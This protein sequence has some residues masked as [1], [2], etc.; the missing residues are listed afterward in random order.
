M[1]KDKNSY[2]P[3]V[4]TNKEE[5]LTII[6]SNFG[7]LS[8][9]TII[10]D[11]KD[12]EKISPQDKTIKLYREYLTEIFNEEILKSWE[13]KLILIPTLDVGWGH[14]IE[15]YGIAIDLARTLKCKVLFYYPTEYATLP[16]VELLFY[17]LKFD[18]LNAMHHGNPVE[19]VLLNL[20]NEI[21][22]AEKIKIAVLKTLMLPIFK[23]TQE[24]GKSKNGDKS[25][26]E[27]LIL[28]F[29]YTNR[30]LVSIIARVLNNLDI[31]ITENFFRVNLQ[32]MISTLAPAA[33]FTTHPYNVRAIRNLPVPCIAHIPDPGYG[34]VRSE[35]LLDD[36]NGLQQFSGYANSNIAYSVPTH[37]IQD[38]LTGIYGIKGQINITGTTNNHITPEELKKKWSDKE[39]T[40]LLSSNGNGSNIDMLTELVKDFINQSKLKNNPY[41]II[42]FTGEH[43]DSICRSIIDLLKTIPEDL[44][45]KVL[46]IRTADKWHT[47]VKK[48]ELIKESHVEI[49]SMGEQFINI[50]MGCIPIATKT[51][52]INECRNTLWAVNTKS[53]LAFAYK[54]HYDFW[55]KLFKFN[56]NTIG[57]ANKYNNLIDYLDYIFFSDN[58]IAKTILNYGYT[59]FSTDANFFNIAFL[60][61]LQS[62]IEG[63]KDKLDSV[64]F[65]LQKYREKGVS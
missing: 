10:I 3:Q 30:F 20:P 17:N 54:E 41:K 29:L 52:P 33:V 22:F 38:I 13:N 45:D 60:M 26:F 34:P 16:A 8:Q 18:I 43:N 14:R 50:A 31:F 24:K 56:E 2:T 57:F 36:V 37:A 40:I 7:F 5:I 39:R 35:G 59:R 25:I 21:P 61:F 53:G 11:W 58:D 51:N 47:A 49:R 48:L 62:P 55:K 19:E 44:Q 32:K 15:A 12:F 42:F 27:K 28:P 6:K 23:V 65:E 64:K 46:H 9:T 4:Y 1:P 63:F